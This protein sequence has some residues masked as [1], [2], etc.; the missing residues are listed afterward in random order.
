MDWIQIREKDL[1]ARELFNL[2]R[3]AVRMAKVLPSARASSSTTVWMSRSQPGRRE[4]I[5]GAN[6]WHCQT[7]CGGAARE[8]AARISDRRFVPS[9]R[10]GARSG[11]LRRKLHF[12]WTGLRH[13][14]KA[15]IWTAPGNRTLTQS[16]RGGPDT[17]DC[18]RRNHRRKGRGSDGSRSRRELLPF[19]CSRNR[20]TRR[21]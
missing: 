1:P 9:D 10:G 16:M 15:A 11:T 3:G 18:H 2:T 12:L 8:C 19:A 13:A 21:R 14:V 4:C 20:K 5:S 6:P 17:R 7:W